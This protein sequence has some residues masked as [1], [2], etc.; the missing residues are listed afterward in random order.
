M[1]HQWGPLE[2]V[3]AALGPRQAPG[4]LWAGIEAVRGKE[5]PWPPR[6]EAHGEAGKGHAPWMIEK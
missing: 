4:G 1:D 3:L 6:R 2:S 5:R